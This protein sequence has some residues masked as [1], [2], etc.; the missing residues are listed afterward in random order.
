[1]TIT[2]TPLRISFAGGGKD[3]REFWQEH[4]GAY[5]FPPKACPPVVWRVY[6][7]VAWRTPV[8]YKNKIPGGI[9][10]APMEWTSYSIGQ[11][12]HGIKISGSKN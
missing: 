9:P 11:G 1:V 5:P 3:F 6:P 12:F 10:F 2:H 7:P 4:G 8:K